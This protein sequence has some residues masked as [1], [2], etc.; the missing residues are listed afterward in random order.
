MGFAACGDAN[1][2]PTAQYPLEGVWGGYFPGSSADDPHAGVE[3][4][5]PRQGRNAFVHHE[6]GTAHRATVSVERDGNDVTLTF[7]GRPGDSSSFHGN[8]V[9]S[10]RIRGRWEST[11]DESFPLD[12][13][14]PESTGLV[15]LT[16]PAS[17]SPLAVARPA[18][19]AELAPHVTMQI[20]A[21]TEDGVTYTFLFGMGWYFNPGTWKSPDVIPN[22][23]M[24]STGPS[25]VLQQ[26]FFP[27]WIVLDAYA[28]D[29]QILM[30]ASLEM[31]LADF[32]AVNPRSPRTVTPYEDSF[33]GVW[34]D[35]VPAVSVQLSYVETDDFYDRVPWP[36]RAT[37][38]EYAV[39]YD[40][41]EY[42]VPANAGEMVLGFSG[43]GLVVGHEVPT[44]AN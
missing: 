36:T 20:Q 31:P 28:Y 12:L 32:L 41:K 21:R 38:P 25:A 2:A 43:V 40:G 18:E 16:P 27:S 10:D 33:V 11:R 3:I 44:R 29:S 7:A 6:D 8:F 39:E 30:A 23:Q 17:S 34:P 24:I 13:V 19:T 9:G 42:Q 14:R 4:H 37:D 22:Q 35:D 26:V 5:F 15:P 1:R